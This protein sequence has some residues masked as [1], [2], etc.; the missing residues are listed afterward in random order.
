VAADL[1]P[2][3][4][5]RRQKTV[6][7]DVLEVVLGTGR[8][9]YVQYCCDWRGV[10]V[11]RV[12]PGRWERPLSPDRLRELVAGPDERVVRC[13]LQ[14]FVKGAGIEVVAHLDVP[15]GREA[16]PGPPDGGITMVPLDLEDEAHPA[17]ALR[18]AALGARRRAPAPVDLP[19]ADEARL[20]LRSDRAAAAL[21]AWYSAANAPGAKVYDVVRE[22]VSAEPPDLLASAAVCLLPPLVAPGLPAPPSTAAPAELLDWALER[23]RPG[24]FRDLFLSALADRRLPLSADDV[25]LMCAVAGDGRDAAALRFVVGALRGYFSAH[26]GEPGVVGAAEA[27]LARLAANR[28]MSSA[29]AGALQ[30]L[31]SAQR[32]SGPPDLALLDDG[33]NFAAPVREL[34]TSVAALWPPAWQALAHLAA[35]R[36]S[37][38]S[39]AW[40]ARCRQLCAAPGYSELIEGALVLVTSIDLFRPGEGPYECLLSEQ[41]RL[42]A[43]GAVWATPFAEGPWRAGR[44]GEVAI[45]CGAWKSTVTQPLCPSVSLAA[46]DAL[47]SIGDA[48]AREQLEQLLVEAPNATLLRKAG[49]AL[50][51]SQEDCD[52]AVDGL[53]AKRRPRI[54][55]PWLGRWR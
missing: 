37:R 45:R 38:P 5:R 32:P 33:D 23:R 47:V 14:R 28:T 6:L 20:Q 8:F 12:L 19:V 54:D 15:A 29:S 55:R 27:L 30:H 41:N 4:R 25:E 46:V 36:G 9:A 22:V 39:K 35:A 48:P 34:A 53:R 49:A 1:G 18:D 21:A 40:A 51:L 2:A 31:V 11:A 52:A 10:P 42:V 16:L 26:P 43:R 3:K 13:L 7:G 24:E 50:G 44:L 17:N